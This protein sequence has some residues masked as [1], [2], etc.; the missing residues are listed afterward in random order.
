MA[1]SSR[2]GRLAILDADTL[3]PLV[4]MHD[5]RESIDELKYSPRGGPGILA[6]GSHDL[7]IYLYRVARGYQLIGRCVGHSGTIQHL[8][9]SLPVPSP[10]EHRGKFILQST[11]AAHELLH[12]DPETGRQVSSN[13]RNAP[14]HTWTARLGFPVMGIWPDGSDGTD[15]NAVCRS[16][17]GAPSYDPDAVELEIARRSIAATSIHELGGGGDLDGGA[18]G[19]GA[20]AAMSMDASPAGMR[21]ALVTFP[22]K[23]ECA[24]NVPGAGYLVSADDFAHIK[25]FNYPVV[26]DDAPYKSFRGHASHVMCVRFTCDDRH[27]IS[28]GGHDR[29]IFQWR[30]LGVA[31]GDDAGDQAV[32][33]AVDTALADKREGQLSRIPKPLAPWGAL[34]TVSSDPKHKPKN[35]GPLGDEAR[36]ETADRV[37]ASLNNPEMLRDIF[38]RG[39]SASPL[40]KVGENGVLEGGAGGLKH[41]PPKPAPPVVLAAPP[42]AAIKMAAPLAPAP[43]PPPQQQQQTQVVA[44]QRA[45]AQP[46]YAMASAPGGFDDDDEISDEFDQPTAFPVQRFGAS[47]GDGAQ[48]AMTD[49]AYGA[50][51]GK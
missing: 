10:S 22:H 32:L 46:R 17:R 35:Y 24:D 12:W 6:A 7:K 40:P 33:A 3:Q 38:D 9:W 19:G 2:R 14:W 45:A 34:D 28:V 23:S 15:V 8:D 20:A 44:P 36:R 50:G 41:S 48:R 49:T 16:Q 37:R 21:S 13:Q 5:S 51:R 25:L 27:V 18:G 4:H 31:L 30:T 47:G 39:V 1:V 43:P 11:D 29:A 42:P 26:A